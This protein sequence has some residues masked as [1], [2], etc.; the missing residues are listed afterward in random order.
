MCSIQK[1]YDEKGFLTEEAVVFQ[2]KSFFYDCLNKFKSRNKNMNW[3]LY[4]AGGAQLQLENPSMIKTIDA[5]VHVWLDSNNSSKPNWVEVSK[6]QC[7][8]VSKKS[9]KTKRL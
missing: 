8:T 1:E 6:S 3:V 2:Y 9:S 7:K 4:G 5:D